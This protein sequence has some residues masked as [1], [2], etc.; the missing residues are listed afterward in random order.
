MLIAD[1]KVMEHLFDSIF[2]SLI[3]YMNNRS[4]KKESH[5][6]EMK[7]DIRSGVSVRDHKRASGS[8]LK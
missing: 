4:I 1:V 6:T 7:R 2:G 8:L 3:F 5:Q